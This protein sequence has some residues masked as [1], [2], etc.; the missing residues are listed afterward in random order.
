MKTFNTLTD[1]RTELQKFK[2]DYK[3]FH[4]PEGQ[5]VTMYDNAYTVGSDWDAF[6]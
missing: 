4:T 5:R 1:F 3:L 6:S 2:V